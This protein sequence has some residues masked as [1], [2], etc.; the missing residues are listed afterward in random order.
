[1]KNKRCK[2]CNHFQKSVLNDIYGDCRYDPPICGPDNVEAVDCWPIVHA[3]SWCSKFDRKDET[4][5]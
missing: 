4:N 2:Y 1:M 3:V 5:E